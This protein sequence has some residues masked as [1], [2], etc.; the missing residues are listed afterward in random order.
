MLCFK[1]SGFKPAKYIKNNGGQDIITCQTLLHLSEDSIS[2]KRTVGLFFPTGDGWI[3]LCYSTKVGP[4]HIIPPP[5]F[6]TQ[7][8][9]SFSSETFSMNFFPSNCPHVSNIWTERI[10]RAHLMDT[11]H[12]ATVFRKSL[13]QCLS[14]SLTS[15]YYQVLLNY[16]DLC[17]ILSQ[18]WDFVY[19]RQNTVVE[20][21]TYQCYCQLEYIV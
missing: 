14:S 13:S 7:T 5:I 17:Q 18:G 16:T 12:R 8:P 1:T 2:T 6:I 21:K 10:L 4:P 11:V 20:N 19:T 9:E 15:V 3:A